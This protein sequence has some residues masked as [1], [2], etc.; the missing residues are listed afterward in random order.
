MF[1]YTI[2]KIGSTVDQ[3]IT[4]TDECDLVRK[5]I[6]AINEYG[7]ELTADQ[8]TVYNNELAERYNGMTQIQMYNAIMGAVKKQVLP[9]DTIDFEIPAGTAIQNLRAT[10]MGDTFNGD[11][12][13][14]NTTGMSIDNITYVPNDTV[15]NNLDL[16]KT[17]VKNAIAN[18]YQVTKFPCHIIIFSLLGRE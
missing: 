4:D 10:S 1:L 7:N 15:E 18:P 8:Q 6:E 2:G 12:I 16:I 9:L 17:A 13:H 14:L 5:Y 3:Y 11:D